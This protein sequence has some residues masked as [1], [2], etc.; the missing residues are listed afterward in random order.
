[1]DQI[2]LVNR[3]HLRRKSPAPGAGRKKEAPTKHLIV[4]PLQIK[5]SNPTPEILT[6]DIDLLAAERRICFSTSEENQIES[7]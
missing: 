7:V 6:G 5:R 1:M 3:Y 2:C 4:D